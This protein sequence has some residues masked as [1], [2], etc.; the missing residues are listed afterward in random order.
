MNTLL[1]INI[2]EHYQFCGKEYQ[3][4]DIRSN[5]IQLRSLL[6]NKVIIYQSYERLALAHHRGELKKIQEA[7]FVTSSA[8]ILA[9]L[10]PAERTTM[11]NRL[12]FVTACLKA[13]GGRLPRKPTCELA[14]QIAKATGQKTPSYTTI[15]NWKNAYLQLGEDCL[16][17]T[18][19]KRG[20]DLHRFYRQPESVQAIIEDNIA[21]LWHTRTPC[22]QTVL[23][24]SIELALR[25]HNDR[26]QPEQQLHIPSR[27]TLYRIISDLD[28]YEL[29]RYQMDPQDA[30]KKQHWSRKS[31]PLSRRLELVEGD[32]HELDVQTCDSHGKLIGRPW[33]TVLIDVKTRVIVGWDISYN[34]PSTAKTLRAL[35]QSLLRENP[36]GGLATYY[37]VDNGAEFVAE[38]I[39]QIFAQLGTH[40]TFCEIGGPN[41]K[42][43]I[44][45]F[46]GTW[47]EGI[48]QTLRGT[49][50]SKPS[51]YDSEG[52][53][54]YT[55]MEVNE[56]FKKWIETV[57]HQTCHSELNMSPQEAWDI[58]ES[59]KDTFGTKKYDK[60]DLNRR[61]LQVAYITPNNGRLRYKGLAWTAPSIPYLAT[62]KNRAPKLRVLYDE[63]EL[64]HAWVC[65]PKQPTKIFIVKAVSPEYQDGLTMHLHLEIKKNIRFKMQNENYRAARDE[66]VRLLREIA[67][68]N[69]TKRN[70][71]ANAIANEMGDFKALSQL[72]EEVIRTSAPLP[73]TASSSH[74]H[75]HPSTPSKYSVK[76]INNGP[77][78]K[79][80]D[81]EEI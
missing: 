27:S 72:D 71:K 40:I 51:R 32:T 69:K 52:N 78:T 59:S 76:E 50:F 18:P 38:R 19:K 28:T 49:T 2:G 62:K 39:K 24:D 8:P 35:K 43:H 53:A 9:A 4:V 11:E 46:F 70:R 33:I 1:K 12:C 56:I 79:G 65:D 73:T 61:F 66:R 31:P 22:S 48:V 75:T 6:T 45:S 5:I 20:S 77:Q 15:Y 44:E 10:S 16:A 74:Y 41:K 7:P 80:N 26:V 57:Y 17:L 60:E 81:P 63:S 21:T 14:S 64:G 68:K 23:I 54:I 67:L 36:Y 58:E 34:P 37:R 13:W 42:P 47:T 3:V 25:D 29:D 30:L 55:I